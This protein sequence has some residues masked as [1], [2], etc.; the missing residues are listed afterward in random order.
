MNIFM[1]PTIIQMHI[2]LYVSSLRIGIKPS[3]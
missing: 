2:E 3:K 1:S